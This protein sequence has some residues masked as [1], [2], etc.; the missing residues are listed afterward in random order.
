MCQDRKIKMS[1][2]QQIHLRIP[3]SAENRRLLKKFAA[4]NDVSLAEYVRRLIQQSLEV[5]E[6]DY[7]IDMSAGISTWGGAGRKDKPE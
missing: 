1:E 2:K 4:E 6:P 7:H 3:V 5:R